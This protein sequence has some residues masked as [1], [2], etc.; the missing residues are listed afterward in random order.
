V[1]RR[2]SYAVVMTLLACVG[3]NALITLTFYWI[4]GHPVS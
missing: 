2:A 3:V 4:V 1:P